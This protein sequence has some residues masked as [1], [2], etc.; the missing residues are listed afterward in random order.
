MCVSD[1]TRER[2]VEVKVEPAEFPP[3]DDKPQLHVCVVCGHRF[4]RK[5]ALMS[6]CKLHAAFSRENVDSTDDEAETQSKG[7]LLYTS[8]SPRDS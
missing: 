3:R 4:A 6:H 7:C 5:A 2:G 1:C 8:P